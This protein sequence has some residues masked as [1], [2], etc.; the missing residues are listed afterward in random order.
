MIG[1][2]VLTLFALVGC[3]L[4]V[5]SRDLVL[6]QT[7]FRHGDRAPS[8]PY[9]TD[10]YGSGEYW[11]RGWSQLTNEG[12]RQMHALGRFYRHR[13]VHRMKLLAP[14]YRIDEV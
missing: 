11:P 5:T 12:M 3:T 6:V 4:M 14:S 7:I 2:H 1:L 9:P 13:Y 8:L 10:P